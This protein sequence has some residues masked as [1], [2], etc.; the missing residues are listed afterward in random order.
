MSKSVVHFGA[1]LSRDMA[2]PAVLERFVGY[3]EYTDE[4]SAWP[5]GVSVE[6]S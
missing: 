6:N 4:R 5:A 2:F 3:H 1:N